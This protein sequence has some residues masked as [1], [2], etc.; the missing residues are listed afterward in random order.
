MIR[1]GMRLALRA[2][3]RFASLVALGITLNLGLRAALN[4]AM[5][6]SV[7]PP[8]GFPFPFLSYGGSA[9]LFDLV[10]VGVLANIA[11]RT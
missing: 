9:L 4:A 1:C 7:I 10:Q 3:E 5:A 6:L 8:K 11:A 2:R